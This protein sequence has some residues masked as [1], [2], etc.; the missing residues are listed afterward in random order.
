MEARAE[1]GGFTFADGRDVAAAI[2]ATGKRLT[3]IYVSQSDPDYYFS[4]KP[5][6]EAFPEARVL[7]A[8][9]TVSAIARS[10]DAKIAAWAPRLGDEGPRSRADVVMPTAFDGAALAVDGETVEIL[11]AAGLPNR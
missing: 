11:T 7:A 2:A 3:T 5:L 10:V 6:C 9:E 1:D 8:S 4:L